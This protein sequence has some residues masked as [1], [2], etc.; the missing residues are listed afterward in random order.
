MWASSPIATHSGRTQGQQQKGRMAF[1]H[2]S[3]Q[4]AREGRGLAERQSKASELDCSH[5]CSHAEGEKEVREVN[6][7]DTRIP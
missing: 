1:E 6:T 2:C 3:R 7:E 4:I 5:I